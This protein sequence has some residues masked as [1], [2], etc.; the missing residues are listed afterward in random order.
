MLRPFPQ[1]ANITMRQSSLASNQYHAAIFKFEKRVNNGWGGRINYTYSRLEDDQWGETNF[2]SRNGANAQDA[3][4]LAAEYDRSILDVPHKVVLSP[5]VELPFGEGKRWLNS[6]HRQPDP[7]RLDGLVDHLV[8]ERLP[9]HAAHAD[10]RPGLDLR[11]D[12]VGQRGRRRPGDRRRPQG[13]HRRH[14]A[15]LR[16]ATRNPG[17]NALGTL[18]RVDENT[19]TPH[20]N[21][22]DFVATKDV[23]FGGSVRGQF[24]L[25]VLNITDTVKTRGPIETLGSGE[26]RPDPR[27]VGLHAPDAADVPALVLGGTRVL[28]ARAPGTSTL[29]YEGRL[30]RS[31]PSCVRSGA[32]STDD[33]CG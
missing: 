7:R 17:T 10:Q 1:F 2:F 33:T 6:G 16:P 21:N 27:A 13:A 22:W 18:G 23:R 9:G 26:L 32:R 5:I 8:R 14:L 24:R 25:E 19:R 12:A 4:N 30:A 11:A 15:R 3:Y 28:G 31:R 29:T 20:R